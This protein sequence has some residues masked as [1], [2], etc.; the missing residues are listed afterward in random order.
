MTI[1]ALSW[2]GNTWKSSIINSHKDPYKEWIIERLQWEWKQIKHYWET[3]R[4]LFYL[5][6]SEENNI[7]DLTLFQRAINAKEANRVHEVVKDK[8][9]WLNVILDRTRVDNLIYAMYNIDNWK[10]ERF[11]YMQ[12]IPN[13]YEL[14]DAIILF[15]KPIKSTKNDEF[16][17][18]NDPKFVEYFNDTIREQYWDKVIEFDNAEKDWDDIMHTILSLYNNKKNLSII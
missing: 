16:N 15:T 9:K 7:T 13:S 4:E 12:P 14:Y 17:L 8:K 2:V 11:D 3:A 10:C 18:Y 1:I 5:L 6:P